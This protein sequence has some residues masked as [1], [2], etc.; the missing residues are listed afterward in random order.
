MIHGRVGRY[1][2]EEAGD[3][4]DRILDLLAH[5]FWHSDDE[6]AKRTYLS[7]AADAARAEYANDA[8]IDYFERLVPLLDE[9]DRIATMLKLAKVLQLVGALGRAEATALEARTLAAD[10]GDLLQVAWADASLAE[11]AKR[12]SR[13]EAAVA[14]LDAA[15]GRFRDL[16]DAAGVGDMLHLAGVIAQLQGDYATAR[17]RYEDSRRVREGIDDWAGVATTGGNLAILAEFDGDY[18]AALRINDDALGLRRRIGDRRGIGIGEM[19]AGY[20]RILNGDLESARNHL[21]EALRL[22]RE[23]GDRAMIAH[24]TFTLG[25]AMRDLGDHAAAATRYA[26]AL[27]LQ[28]EL[29][30]RFSLTFIVEDVGVLLAWAGEAEQG[31]ELLGGAEAVREQIGSPRPPTL[32]AEL[33]GHF[34][35][36]RQAL[37]DEA[38][39]AAVTRG[40]AWSFEEAI[41]AALGASSRIGA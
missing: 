3:G 23:L 37:G 26:E 9:S 1:L 24:S 38:A 25:N 34:A 15:L 11:T 6:E 41:E 2:E 33:A 35:A 21:E 16:E 17:E 19:N 36:A 22:S 27:E 10:S 8:A 12:Q 28:R 39:D 31:F 7:R 13:F 40:K 29:D 32:D 30:D 14:R 5:H 18:A 20:Y 4:I